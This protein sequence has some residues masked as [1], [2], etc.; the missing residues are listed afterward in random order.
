MTQEIL[1]GRGIL[2][3]DG[4]E[5]RSDRY[6]FVYLLSKGNSFSQKGEWELAPMALRHSDIGTRCT[7]RA[8][9]TA[10]RQSRH[11]GDLF[12]GVFPKT[13]SVGEVITL[14]TGLLSAEPGPD[15]GIQVGLRPFDDDRTTMWLDIKALYRCHEQTVEL[16]YVPLEETK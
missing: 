16:R 7:L 13:P 11:I 3:W 5:R 15:G 14:G 10:T 1:I 9:V 4:K 6:G 2:T 12:H 8:L